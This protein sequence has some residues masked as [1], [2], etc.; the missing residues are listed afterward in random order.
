MENTPSNSYTPPPDKAITHRALIL[1]AIAD[2]TT[3]IFNPSICEDTL[4]TAACLKKLGVKINFLKKSLQ[5]EGL[6]LKGLKEPAGPLSAGES[7]TTM[8]LMAGLLA[9]QDFNSVLTGRGSLL[10]RPMARLTEPLS[11]MGARISSQNGLAPL[12]ISGAPLTGAR[13]KLSVPSAQ[14]K[15]AALLAGLY[16]DGRTSVTERFKTRDHTERLL[17]HFGAKITISGLT[18]ILKPGPLSAG[19]ITIPGDISSAAPFIAAALLSDRTLLIKNVGLNPSRLGFLKTLK[20][21][22]VRLKIKIKKTRPE[23]VGVIQ[24]FPARLKGVKIAPDEIP[25][26]ID[27]LALLALLAA[28]AEG[29]TIIQGVTELRHK[30]SDRIKT[31]LLLLERLGIKASFKTDSLIITGPQQIR[32]GKPIE[33]FNDHRIAMAAAVGNLIAG[34]PVITKGASCVRKSYPAFFADFKKN[35]H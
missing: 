26:M 2:G 19:H 24:V 3:S 15:S 6:G 17:K 21:M 10:K 28:S 18:T 9:G 27:E 4:A 33:T 32:G 13:L 16:A 11:A 23:P 8:R 29:K 34:K 30:E 1:A 22:G 5:V 20:K 7:G 12:K 25:S 14:V 35:F 31:T